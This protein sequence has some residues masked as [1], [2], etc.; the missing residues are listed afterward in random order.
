MRVALGLEYDGSRFCGWQSQT[1]RCGVQD[2]LEQGLAAVAASPVR[3]VTAGRTDTGV[4]A[5]G[6]VVH[7]DTRVARPF[8]AWVR[9][10]NAALPDGVAV[11]W[12]REVAE[13]FHARF[14][15]Y[16][17]TY[18]YLL[19]NDPVRPALLAQ[20]AG[21]FHL[22]LDAEA[23]AQAAGHLVGTHDF[24]AF[25]AAECQAKSPV[26]ELRRAEVKREWRFILFEF[27]ANAFLHHMVRNLVGCL[28]YVGKGAHPPG[29]MGELLEGRDRRRA[30][31]TFAPQGLYFVGPRYEAKWGVPDPAPCRVP[32]GYA[33]G[34]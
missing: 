21:W 22:P 17:R 7:F 34:T 28:V 27:A 31:P 1:P 4:H 5:L 20:K 9:G 18:R 32:I 3:V 19:L 6:Q 23:M 13:D 8:S 16:E 24:S 12:A 30:A 25:R 33:S 29:W 15:A 11:L 2:V 26:K 14:A 10:V